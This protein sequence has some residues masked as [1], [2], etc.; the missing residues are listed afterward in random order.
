MADWYSPSHDWLC[1]ITVPDLFYFALFFVAGWIL[2][3]VNPVFF[4]SFVFFLTF[5]R[6]SDKYLKNSF[7]IQYVHGIDFQCCHSRNSCYC[8]QKQSSFYQILNPQISG[9]NRCFDYIWLTL[10]GQ[11]LLTLGHS[12]TSVFN[13]ILFLWEL[14]WHFC[15]LCIG[16][17]E[18]TTWLW[19]TFEIRAN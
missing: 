15:Y 17:T 5:E 12:S 14:T 9:I 6:F 16:Y 7:S 8:W 10:P 13:L 19:P 2:D 1:I 11:L 18:M 4:F 3:T